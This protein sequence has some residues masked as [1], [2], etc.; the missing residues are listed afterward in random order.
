MR[1]VVVMRKLN[2]DR[3]RWSISEAWEVARLLKMNIMEKKLEDV[4]R[5]AREGWKYWDWEGT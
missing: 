3:V 4:G 1:F 5:V 2:Q